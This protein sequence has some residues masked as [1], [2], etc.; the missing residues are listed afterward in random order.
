MLAIHPPHTH[1]IHPP[2]P[3]TIIL[4]YLST[5]L[6]LIL[7]RLQTFFNEVIF[8]GEMKLYSAEEVPCQDISYQVDPSSS[9]SSPSL[10]SYLSPPS[11]TTP[12]L[13]P[14]LSLP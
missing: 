11:S 10:S 4:S 8:E 9:P 12:S 3:H 2:H 5:L 6:V 7:I 1:T 13:L 14:S